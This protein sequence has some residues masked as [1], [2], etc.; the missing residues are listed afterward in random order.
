MQTCRAAHGMQS[1]GANKRGRV[2]ICA[3]EIS[4]AAL[5]TQVLS[6]AAAPAAKAALLA[7]GMPLQNSKWAYRAKYHITPLSKPE[8]LEGTRDAADRSIRVGIEHTTNHEGHNDGSLSQAR[9]KASAGNGVVHRVSDPQLRVP[10]DLPM[11][12]ASEMPMCAA[13]D[14]P[15]HVALDMPLHVAS[16]LPLRVAYNAVIS[17]PLMP[18]ANASRPAMSAILDPMRTS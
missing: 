13:S 3:A 2:R 8:D 11:R 14:M 7:I 6:K 12:V 10:S 18:A 15:L 9:S 4:S 16:N 5:Y 1:R 17:G